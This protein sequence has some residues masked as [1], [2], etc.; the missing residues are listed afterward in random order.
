[1]KL[2]PLPMPALRP[3]TGP[4]ATL[5]C[6]VLAAESSLAELTLPAVIANGMILQQTSSVPV[7]GS[8]NPGAKVQ[9]VASWGTGAAIEA[10]GMAD[11]DGRWSVALATPKATKE[12]G[13]IMIRSGSDEIELK[14]VLVGEVWLCSGQSN[15]EWEISK[16]ID[17]ARERGELPVEKTSLEPAHIRHF[18]VPRVTATEPQTAGGGKWVDASG[19]DALTCSAVAYFFAQR[20]QEDVDVPVGLIVSSWGGTPA[21]SWVS[22]DVV[23]SF[24]DHART[25]ADVKAGANAED[26]T[27]GQVAEFWDS[28]DD[29]AFFAR[30]FRTADFD[31][32]HWQSATLPCTFGA[33]GLGQFNGVVWFRSEVDV[34]PSWAGQD[35][36]L[37]LP[38]IDDIDE[39]L[40]NGERVGSELAAG[41]WSVKRNYRIPAKSVT[42]GKANLTIRALDTGG[43]GGFG[44]GA[45]RLVNGDEWIDLAGEWRYRKGVTAAQA[46]TPP[47]PPRLTAHTPTALYNAMIAPLRPFGIRG[48]I[49]YQGE[50]NRERA[51][52]YRHLFPALIVNWR[53]HWDNLELPFYFVQIAPF[54]YDG[55][56]EGVAVLRESQA[57]AAKLPG[58]G[59]ALTA[60]IGNPKDIHPK[61]K[62]E[63][64]RRLALFALRDLYGQDSLEPNGPTF[65]DARTDGDSLIVTFDHV[66][67]A[68]RMAKGSELIEHFELRNAEGKFTPATATITEDGQAVRLTA[69][70]IDAPVAARYLWSDD[71]ESTLCGGTGLPVAP[72]RTGR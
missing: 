35:L 32:S 65:R 66:A 24:P 44:A 60:D 29:K 48:V 34:P 10:E 7:W 70:G 8:A 53:K 37:Q 18:T 5:L 40:W 50:S 4:L 43:R 31:D 3:S 6:A 14:D 9:V 27:T 33:L 12:P 47:R 41:A 2:I 42:A 61:N 25:L 56:E 1:M 15:M 23:A 20:L 17:A 28:A 58:T 57:I 21:Q 59:M 46:G 19:S 71:I 63:V 54:D 68:L 45:M 13:T 64:G 67:G 16:S 62:W 49:W 11:A 55:G 39:T 36:E 72:F 51:R 30:R 69:D 22:E 52:E 38:P 26:L